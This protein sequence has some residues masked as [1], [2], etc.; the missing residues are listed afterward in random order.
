MKLLPKIHEKLENAPERLVISNCVTPTEKVAEYLGYHLKAV[1]QRNCS[2][3]KD[4]GG[5]LEKIKNFGSLPENF[6]L[7]STDVIGFYPGIPHQAGLQAFKE[8]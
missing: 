2:Y 5:F 4:S 8:G 7:V 1:M 6:I 3:I